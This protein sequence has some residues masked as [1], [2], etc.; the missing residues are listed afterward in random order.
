M[1]KNYTWLIVGGAVVLIAGLGFILLRKPK[2]KEVKSGSGGSVIEVDPTA[3]PTGSTGSTATQLTEE[4]KNALIAANLALT[5]PFAALFLNTGTS[6]QAYQVKTLGSKLNIRK[7]PSGTGV[8]VKQVANGST[9]YGNP[10]Q[11]AGWYEVSEDGSKMIGYA[12]SLYL[13][14]K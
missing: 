8:L 9:L 2:E 7:T 11:V 5:N 13:V 12:S 10:S 14:K 6:K 3:P 1:K 4:Q